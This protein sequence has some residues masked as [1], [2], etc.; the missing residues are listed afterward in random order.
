MLEIILRD[1]IGHVKAGTHWFRYLCG[2]RGVDS[3]QTFERL[4]REHIPQTIRG[5]FYLD[6]RQQAGFSEREIDFLQ[7]LD[8]ENRGA[9]TERS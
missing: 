5:P 7:R 2:L 6:G 3:E 9:G 1:E 4:V 8:R